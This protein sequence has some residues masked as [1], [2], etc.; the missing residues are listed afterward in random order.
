ME[1]APLVAL[2]EMPACRGRCTPASANSARFS[3]RLP[4]GYPAMCPKTGPGKVPSSLAV[5]CL[6]IALLVGMINGDANRRHGDGWL[7][8]IGVLG[9][10]YRSYRKELIS[11][12]RN[13]LPRSG[14]MNPAGGRVAGVHGGSRLQEVRL[15]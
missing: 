14:G 7:P 10:A 4:T 3:K 9:R 6:V 2:P 15:S 13:S 11:F 1:S 8:A 12:R 5:A